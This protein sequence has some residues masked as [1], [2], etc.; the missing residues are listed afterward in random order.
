MGA[1]CAPS[2]YLFLPA[3]YIP[4]GGSLT[5]FH[6]PLHSPPQGWTPM[7]ARAHPHLRIRPQHPFAPSKPPHVIPTATARGIFTR[8]LFVLSAPF[9][10]VG[11]DDPVRPCSSPPLH[12]PAIAVLLP[13]NSHM[14]FRGYQPEESLA[15]DVH[16]ICTL[17]VL[18]PTAN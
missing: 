7:S 4:I 9:P 6:P 5:F 14:S 16:G 1:H 11:A 15:N 3:P 2:F 12:T 17:R 13:Q 18:F 8:P 10:S